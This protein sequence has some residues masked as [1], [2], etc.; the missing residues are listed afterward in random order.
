MP[1]TDI[2]SLERAKTYLRIDDTLTADDSEIEAMI[3]GALQ[4]I[5]VCTGHILIPREFT[6]YSR[7]GSVEIY[8]YPVTSFDDEDAEVFPL[9]LKTVYKTELSSITYT[10]GYAEVS[11]IP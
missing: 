3:E 5:E 1:Y 6:A 8:N 2:I 4:F 10:A 9:P 11:A 7:C